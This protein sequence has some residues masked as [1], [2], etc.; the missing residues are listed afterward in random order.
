MVFLLLNVLI[1]VM[2]GITARVEGE[3]TLAW[4]DNL[5]HHVGKAENMSFDAPGLRQQYGKFPQYVYYT[6]SQKRI[7]ELEES[8][9]SLEGPQEK[10]A[11]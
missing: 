2:N 3:G 8:G 11:E 10:G 7:K 1:A 5:Y 9:N 4:L 6:V